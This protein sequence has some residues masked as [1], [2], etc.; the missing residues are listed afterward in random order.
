MKREIPEDINVRII[1]DKKTKLMK[2]KDELD[3]IEISQDDLWFFIRYLTRNTISAV[4]ENKKNLA[5]IFLAFM[6]KKLKT[7]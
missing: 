4:R 2:V 1:P 5:P 7:H 3:K 6:N